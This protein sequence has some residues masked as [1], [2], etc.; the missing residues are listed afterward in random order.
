[1]N[2]SD[3]LANLKG[4]SRTFV[5]HSNANPY[6]AAAAM[7]AAMGRSETL[8]PYFN[9]LR[10]PSSG[11]QAQDAAAAVC[12]LSSSEVK[13]D[14]IGDWSDFLRQKGMAT[15]GLA[16]VQS[17][18]PEDNTMRYLNAHRR[19]PITAPR[20]VHEPRG[21]SSPQGYED[22]YV[23]LKRLI[24]SG[25]DL[26][27]YL[28]HQI[29][30]KRADKNDGL[31]N[32]E[33]I[34]HLHF[35]SGGTKDILLCK[36]TDTDVFV[37]KALPHCDGDD[38]WK[39]DTSPLQILHDNWPEEIAAGKCHKLKGEPKPSSER[40][41]LR[42]QNA[43]FTTT[44][45]D[46]TVYLAPGGG[47]MASGDCSDDRRDCD[48][49][50]A[51]LAHWQSVVKNNAARFRAALNWPRSKEL[52]IRMMFDHRDCWLYEPTTGSVIALTMQE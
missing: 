37:I 45:R 9:L 7:G 15:Y 49:I 8:G 38:E 31:L 52:S 20:M 40:L 10:K 47:L 19:I 30:R 1:M 14:F 4:Y 50:F 17:R 27:P 29:Q 22:G 6:A 12:D 51:E 5:V 48:R 13:V 2:T 3:L 36:I 35:R 43:N 24:T 39:V 26:K 25:G 33:G 42:D 46:G 16:Y 23:A 21:W 41:A 28:S 18:S 11:V 32:S 34:Q 44:M